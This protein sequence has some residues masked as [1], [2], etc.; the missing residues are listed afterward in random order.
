[1]FFLIP[2]VGEIV[3]NVHNKSEF[4]SMLEGDKY[5]EQNTEKKTRK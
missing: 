2:P 4:Y 5:Y 3:N 1:M